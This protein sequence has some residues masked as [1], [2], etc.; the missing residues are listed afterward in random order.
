MLGLAESHAFGLVLHTDEPHSHVNLLLKA[1]NEQG[2]RLNIKKETLCHWHSE[3]ARNLRALGVAAN[4]TERAVG[5][6]SQQAK[7]DGICRADL[8]GESVYIRRQAKAVAAELREGN[9]NGES[10]KMQ[11]AWD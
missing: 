9:L 8:R 4:A 10:R 11:F 5:G 3:F 1:V 6:Q 7:R 2:V